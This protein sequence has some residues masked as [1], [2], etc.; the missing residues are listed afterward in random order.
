MKVKRYA[1]LRAAG[2]ILL[3]LCLV[4]LMPGCADTM[5]STFNSPMKLLS[6]SGVSIYRIVCS[7]DGA[8]AAIK[9]AAE[10]TQAAMEHMLGVDV[11]LV[12]DMDK[13]EAPDMVLPY[14]ILIG[15]TARKES[16]E[17]LATLGQ[18]EWIVRAVGH[19]IVI[20]GETN[21][22]TLSAVEHFLTEVLGYKGDGTPVNSALSVDPK[23]DY[24]SRFEAALIP[25]GNEDGALPGAPHG[26]SVMYLVPMP[27][28][29]YDALSLATLQGL[30]AAYL[31]EHILLRDGTYEYYLPYLVAEGV[32]V[33]E[34][35]DSDEAWT[36]GSLLYRYRDSLDGYLLC[37]PSP[38]SE[39]AYVAVSLAHHLNA[40]VMTP[41]NEQLAVNA[42]LTCVLDVTDKDDS[43]LRASQYFP[44]LD[45]ALAVEQSAVD[46]PS[47]VDYAVMTGCY[48]Y[49]YNGSDEYLHTQKFKFLTSGA[50]VLLGEGA[51][52]AARVRSLSNI[53]LSPLD[54]AGLCNLSTLSG[55]LFTAPSLGKMDYVADDIS[56]VHTVC[57]VMSDGED[58]QWLMSDFTTSD[59]WYGSSLRGEFAVNWGVPHTVYDVAPPLISYLG[60][61]AT[62]NDDFVLQLPLL[63]YTYTADWLDMTRETLAKQYSDAMQHM[64]LRYAQIPFNGG[65]DMPMI[66]ALTHQ[67]HVQGMLYMGP[68]LTMGF[69]SYVQWVNQKP[70]VSMRYRMTTMAADGTPTAIAEAVNAAPA[71]VRSHDSYSLI[72]IDAKT[73]LDGD[74]M[75]VDGGDTMAAVAALV[76]QLGEQVD[77]VSVSE[78]MARI[79]TY[80]R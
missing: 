40:V 31:G 3:A 57:L 19:K 46:A 12:D 7:L 13:A 32:T 65:Y 77:V 1:R 67:D 26:A 53:N 8:P 35:D 23:Y 54:V 42:G 20:L 80:L 2:A 76:E 47:L 74:G 50:H 18:D 66:D 37:N 14:E 64:L 30:A 17:A 56:G 9:D 15:E 39:S 34:T 68:P 51:N 62:D 55:C 52:G 72:V 5:G 45:N 27:E 11:S 48:F 73:G 10:Q 44:L 60:H 75:L 16:Q 29:D 41:D 59:A 58:L 6:N 63:G 38:S 49:Y 21:R 78:F 69:N 4:L 36:L 33:E 70:V 28:N 71:D 43:W 61:S 25:N 22:A 24:A 79:N